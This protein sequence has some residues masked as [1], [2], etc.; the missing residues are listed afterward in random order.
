MTRG[1]LILHLHQNKK[2]QNTQIFI[3]TQSIYI[4]H[5]DLLLNKA[6][7][8]VKEHYKFFFLHFFF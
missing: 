8:A 7:M 1:R 4:A 5:K 6:N 3:F 2:N